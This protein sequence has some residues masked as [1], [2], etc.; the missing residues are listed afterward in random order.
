M[1]GPCI[2]VRREV[3]TRARSGRTPQVR[4][5]RDHAA[6][7]LLAFDKDGGFL[8]EDLAARRVELGDPRDRGLLTELALGVVRHQGTLD[9]VLARHSR[10]PLSTLQRPVRVGLR[11]GA[12]Q[13]LF[14]DR[15]PEH[16]AVD[17]AVTWVT[18]QGGSQ[19]AGYVNAVL[20]SMLRGIDG[21]STARED[22]TRD[23]VR[24]DGTRVR[25]RKPV[26]SR[27]EQD[28]SVGL[29]QRF[30][31]PVWLVRRWHAAFGLERTEE[32][33]RQGIV[34]PTLTL[35][36]RR[37]RKALLAE[38]EAQGVASV[39][40][41]V[42]GAV[43]VRGDDSTALEQVTLGNAAVQDETSQRVVPLLQ[44]AEGN[45]VLDLC[46]APGG[47]S[48][49]IAD[50]LRS[51]HL[52][53]TDVDAIKVEGLA[54][55]G[56]QI[57]GVTFEARVV[58]DKGPL[59]FEPATFDR[60]LVDAP[61]SNT[62]VLRRRVEARWRLEK[63]D[64][65]S[66]ARIQTALLARALPLLK[67]GGRLVYATCSVELEENED[68]VAATAAAFPDITVQKGFRVPPSGNADGGYAAVMTR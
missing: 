52:V 51:G 11:L 6:E 36:A 57:E 67:P 35:R 24:A 55:L 43:Y 22:P 41:Q 56:N 25:F 29:A 53:A 37:G 42:S 2:T 46:A 49:Q 61:C 47:K 28:P 10:R 59:P 13:V 1:A 7:L 20:R 68:V 63:K 60:I 62:G 66:L 3:P 33:L 17:H 58:Q 32:L 18:A 26:F 12:Y 50:A 5:A 16:A 34:R 39:A 38:L 9:A 31:M 21:M 27:H 64:F 30:S 4:T 65:A 45:R 54:A 14:L 19:R 8:Q 40:G 44:L 48:L 15:V 23:V